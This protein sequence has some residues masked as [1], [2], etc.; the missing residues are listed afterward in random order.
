MTWIITNTR[1]LRVGMFCIF[2][3][4]LEGSLAEKYAHVYIFHEI[5]L[6]IY[7]FHLLGLE[8]EQKYNGPHFRRPA[9][10]QRSI[11]YFVITV[12]CPSKPSKRVFLLLFP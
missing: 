12:E 4:A 8:I 3:P 9:I 5:Q 1:I 2:P 6:S 11:N 10:S 7:F